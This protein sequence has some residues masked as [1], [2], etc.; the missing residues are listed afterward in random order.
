MTR[1]RDLH[2]IVVVDKPAGMTSA[3]VVAAAR[4]RIG[5]SRIGHTGTLDPLATGVLPLCLGEGT[6]LASYLLADDKGYDAELELGVETD[7][8]DAEGEVLARAPERAAAVTEADVRAALARF[9]G[10]LAQV[11][12]MFSAL[13]LGGRRLHE[14]ARDGVEIVRQ[15]RPVTIHRLALLSFT[16]PRLRVAVDCSKGTYVRTLVADLGQA[17]GCGAHL[18]ALRRTRSGV[19]T[20]EHAVGLDDVRDAPML[21]LPDSLPVSRHVIPEDQY[22]A[23]LD[24]RLLPYDAVEPPYPGLADGAPVVDGELGPCHAQLLTPE[25]ALAALARVTDGQLRPFRVFTYGLT[26]HASSA[27]LRRSIASNP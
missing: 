3:Q 12:P 13:K 4:K 14:L 8:Y 25:G 5:T 21:S 6:K 27:N 24:G 10:D 15:P 26:G 22:R 20:L 2:G 1:R 23:L 7:T 19:F 16:P 11:P 9:T 17:L 18:T